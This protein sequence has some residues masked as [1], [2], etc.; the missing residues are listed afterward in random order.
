MGHLCAILRG[1]RTLASRSFAPWLRNLRPSGY[2]VRLVFLWLPSADFAIERVA[3]RVRVGGH[4][5]QAENRP[6]PI[7]S[8]P[9][10]LLQ[11][12]RPT[13]IELAALRQLHPRAST[14][15]DPCGFLSHRRSTMK[16][17]GS[18]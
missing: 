9:A 3:E 1:A 14:Y 5:V 11:L 15:C 18:S 8:G 4:N 6:S 13:R 2:E 10:Q 16:T 12:V 17:H 7:S